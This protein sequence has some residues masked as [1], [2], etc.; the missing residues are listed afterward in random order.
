MT[1][2]TKVAA[3]LS[4]VVALIGALAIA[5]AIERQSAEQRSQFRATNVQALELLALAV[6]PSVAE[7]RHHRAQAVLDNVANF[8]ERYPDV[9]ALEVLD[10]RGRVMAD[11][12]PRRFGEPAKPAPAG[13]E[14]DAPIVTD[15][16]SGEL[17]VAV[18][19]RLAHPVGLMRARLT[20][21]RLAGEV[22]RLQ[23][24]AALFV[25]ATMALAG[26]VLYLLHRRM[27]GRPIAALAQAATELRAGRMSARAEERG[28]DEIGVLGRAF[29]DMATHLEQYTQE[30]ETA[31]RARTT[32]LEAVNRRL[33]EL[34]TTD[35]LTG[36]WNR[37]HFE[38]CAARIIEQA[39]RAARPAALVLI[40]VDRFKSYNDRFGHA[41]GDRVLQ[42]V[43][44]QL[45]SG[46]RAMDIV[47][48]VGGEEFV[49]MM[50][51]TDAHSAT[52]AAERMRESLAASAPDG[53]P[54][55]AEHV[56]A[57][58]GVAT[59]P[60]GGDRLDRLLMSADD[61]LYA[62]KR[63]GRNRMSVAPLSGGAQSSRG[64][65]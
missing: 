7:G 34:A 62:A 61:A 35:A 64:S 29:N 2:S 40:D 42:H 36:L 15:L 46:A 16:G 26:V 51:D 45:R 8:P 3:A 43:A 39:R 53:A 52:C 25:V 5:V 65:A 4:L 27:L 50:P 18:P 21:H 37:R 9:R 41:V 49:V 6:A 47:A 33:E 44:K 11:L 55:D 22:F 31:V 32:E 30:L 63:S 56:T 23:R 60:Q 28:N 1:L 19:L 54:P 38:E 10:L 14:A 48:R 12:D 59:F 20:E 13:Q 57:S 58:F 24:N 17:E